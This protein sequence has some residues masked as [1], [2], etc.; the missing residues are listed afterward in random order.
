LFDA[1]RLQVREKKTERHI[2][3]DSKETSNP[4]QHIIIMVAQ[5]QSSSNVWTPVATIKFLFVCIGMP[6]LIGVYISSENLETVQG[7]FSSWSGPPPSPAVVVTTMSSRQLLE[8]PEACFDAVFAGL[9]MMDGATNPFEGLSMVVHRNGE[10]TPCDATG[11]T[12]DIIDAM[13]ET[14]LTMEH[15]PAN[16]KYKFEAF[17]T[18]LFASVAS[19]CTSVEKDRSPATGL[20]GFCDM[21]AKKTPILQDHKDLVG[22]IAQDGTTYLPCHFHDKYGVR[23]TSLAQLATVARQ[24]E[25]STSCT[26]EGNEQE[27]CATTN[28]SSDGSGSDSS[29]VLHLY[30]VPAGRVFMFAPS[31]IGEIIQLPHVIGDDPTL[32]VY[33]EVLSLAPRVFDLVNFFS[34]AESAAVVEGALEESKDSHK[35]KRSSTGA[36]GY[37]INKHRTS[38]SGY[39]T[40]SK[41]AMAIKK[42]CF[43]VLGFDQYMESH[44]DGLQVLRYN[45]TTVRTSSKE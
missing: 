39:D 21:G 34:R 9:N 20:Y 45:L 8:D 44:A 22:S 26:A 4:F 17:L 12:T 6:Y 33:L 35:I 11:S 15:C 29:R 36:T 18:R 40:S 3:F 38:E 10:S 23:M 43:D 32:P 14:I 5:T 19:N 41:T 30:A 24:A 13:K 37:N 7:F 42:R 27:A 16:N 28:S 31:Y 25:T 1:K 2:K